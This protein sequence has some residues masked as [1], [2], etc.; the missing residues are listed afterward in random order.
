MN[1]NV[2][3]NAFVAKP[4]VRLLLVD[5]HAVVRAGYRALLGNFPDMEVVAEADSGEAACREFARVE[6]DVV[7][8]DL[9]LPG[10]GGLEAI[11]RIVARDENA[12]ILVCSMHEDPVFAEQAMAAGARGY[13]TKSSAPQALVDAVRALA[14]GDI[15]VDPSIAQRLAYQKSRGK[16]TP[17]LAL[18][19]REFE[20][21]C[22]LAEGA[23]AA[24]IARRLSLSTKTVANYST[25]IKAKLEVGSVA[26]LAR[27]AI[28]HGI[29]SA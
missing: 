22:M 9:T 23:T 18:S 27:L 20:I 6:P 29:V 5:D 19:A 4:P 1:A 3:A 16:A 11:R 13:L 26:E 12:A 17:F 8:M 28:R 14:S 15:H 24:D 10:M 21:C 7:V 2:T 25:Q